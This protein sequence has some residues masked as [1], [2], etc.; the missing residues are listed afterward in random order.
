MKAPDLQTLCQSWAQYHNTL[1]SFCEQ[2]P[3]RPAQEK[4][5][6]RDL[7]AAVHGNEVELYDTGT[8]LLSKHVLTRKFGDGASFVVLDRSSLLCL[9]DYPPST[10]VFELNLLSFQLISLSPLRVPRGKAGA[11]LLSDSIYVFGGV[12]EW[13]SCERY[14]L[15]SSFLVT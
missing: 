11:V 12:A 7:Y 9:G 14:V 3:P 15:Q 5:V 13:K 10:A 2:L 4:E 6:T 1:N 8:R